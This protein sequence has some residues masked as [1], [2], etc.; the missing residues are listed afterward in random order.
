M[1]E[2]DPKRFIVRTVVI[3]YL[4]LVVMLFFFPVPSDNKEVL[5]AQVSVVSTGFGLIVGYF[6]GSSQG[7][8]KKSDHL[9]ANDNGKPDPP[10]PP[11][12]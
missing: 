12:P 2:F 8:Q 11:Q 10:K 7:S 1:K 3:A 9:M 5:I 4:G 6:F